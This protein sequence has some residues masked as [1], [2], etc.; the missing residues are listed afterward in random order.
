MH[1]IGIIL[2]VQAVL[3]VVAFWWDSIAMLM[4]DPIEPVEEEGASM[5]SL[6]GPTAEGNIQAN[7]RNRGRHPHH[8]SVTDLE[9]SHKA[10]PIKST[11]HASV[12]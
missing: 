12:E 9:R 4:A 5:R 10:V 1:I 11:S 3:S 8:L 7:V 6:S 2:A